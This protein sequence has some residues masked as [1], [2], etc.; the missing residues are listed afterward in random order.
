MAAPSLGTAWLTELRISIAALAMLA[1][2]VV[3][4]HKLE[5]RRNLRAYAVIGTLQVALPWAMYAY[6]GHYLG[7]GY[8]SLLN[9]STPS[10]SAL[11]G[12]LW[13]G[14]P[15]T[16][17]VSLGLL[18]GAL[19]V[20]LVV[21]FGPIEVTP[22]VL[23]SAAMCVA[24]SA[25]YALTG[26]YRKKYAAD[27]APFSLSLGTLLFAAPLI[28]PF[29][30]GMPGADVFT[31]KIVLAVL[32]LALLGSALAFILYFRLMSDI[33]PTKTQTVTFITPLFGILFGILFLDEE[34][35]VAMLVGGALILAGTALVVMRHATQAS[36]RNSSGA[37]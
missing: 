4:G 16:R 2:A 1:Y 12:A 5:L 24:G 17:R 30:P 10:F 13:L 28:W 34:L 22:T 29:L 19:G 8:L 23:L 6:A 9:A 20:A 7:A 25:G 18:L 15:L 21:G 11:F 35:R 14:E 32:G 27:V 26:I 33:G 3:I 37:A 36:T 31:W